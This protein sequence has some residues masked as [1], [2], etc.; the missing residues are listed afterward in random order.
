M[1]E[2]LR[3]GSTPTRISLAS[4]G[5]MWVVP[6][7]LPQHQYPLT[8]FHQEWWAALLGLL[9][10]IPLLGRDA[11]RDPGLPHILL[12]PLGLIAVLLLQALLL[13]GLYPQTLLLYALYLLFA[14]LL[15]MLGA[16]LRRQLGMDTLATWLAVALL[17]GA[18]IS[19]LL[20]ILQHFRW[21]TWLDPWVV[22]KSDRSVYGNLAQAN[23]FADYITLGLASLGLL[24]AQRRV[25]GG[26]AALL[27]LPLL[28]VATLSASRSVWLYLLLLVVL[29]G[30]WLRRQPEA[31]TLWRYALLLVAGF[32]LMHLLIK[33][34]FMA[35]VDG[36]IDSMERLFGTNPS[37]AIRLYLWQEAWHIFLQTPWLGTGLGRF[38]WAHVQ[39]LPELQP[40]VAITGLY[41][42]AHNLLF[43]IGVET[44]IAGLLIVIPALG[45]WL[46]GQR[47]QAATPASWWG[48]AVLGVL[49]IHSLLEFPLW[50]SFFIG[51][52]ALLLG[53]MDRHTHVP[54]R[55]V[56]GRPAM[57]GVL[58]LGV[59]TLLQL[60]AD[61]FHLES[62]LRQRLATVAE[63]GAAERYRDRLVEMHGTGTLL[64]PYVELYMAG[65]IAYTEENLPA[66]LALNARV[67][68]FAPTAPAMYR[69]AVLL[70]LAG[71]QAEAERALLQAIRSYPE[72][73]PAARPQLEALAAKGFATCAALIESGLRQVQ[74]S[75]RA[76]PTR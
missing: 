5:L 45:Y 15:M 19:A 24:L 47:G 52:A 64:M 70:A 4:V 53:A 27:A 75:P 33:L 18:E 9:A 11:W 41:N 6:F 13:P 69:Q 3:R 35:G 57:S 67:E 20:G 62:V 49:G 43:Q 30:L 59:L 68:H 12:L 21:P 66:K 74:E 61:Y 71:R 40:Q 55:P 1:L 14:A 72:G 16:H 39:W 63:V 42:N 8:T 48:A 73:F 50:Y 46:A 37:G 60:R 34:P 29:A 2:R 51:I 7:L 36:N 25:T 23:H 32:G 76:V 22:V 28:L 17:L 54:R 58:L 38:A 10:A 44:G 31:R 65:L 56:W 26:L